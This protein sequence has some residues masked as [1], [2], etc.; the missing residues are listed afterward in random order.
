VHPL[1]EEA[2]DDVAKQQGPRKSAGT[3]LQIYKN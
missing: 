2:G 3:L 1:P